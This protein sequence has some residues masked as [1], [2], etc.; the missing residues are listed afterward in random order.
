MASVKVV[1]YKWKTLK[2]GEHPVMIRVIKDRIDKYISLG[3][4]CSEDLW[5]E[6]TNRPKK[7][8]PLYR[9][10]LILI[11]KKLLEANKLI[12]NNENE[13]TEYTA[14]ELIGKIW[15]KKKYG[16]V[17]VFQFFDSIIDQLKI[18]GRIGYSKV[19]KNTKTSLF[20]FRG[21]KDFH[22]NDI[23]TAF[24]LKYEESF[25]S[26][27]VKPNSIFVFMRTLKTL[28]NYAKKNDIVKK[29][30]DPFKDYS[31]AKFRHI[32][33]RKRAL[34][35][36]DIKKIEE[37]KLE[38][39]SSIF[40]AKNYFLFSFY[41]RGLNFID[42]ANLKW[43]SLKGD[44]LN[45]TRKKTKEYFNI[46]LLGPAKDILK[47]Y[48][49][50]YYD[51]P[52]SYIFPILNEKH[53]TPASIDNR[54]HKVLKQTN[55]DLKTIA[56]RVGITD[57]LTTYVARH[58]YATILKKSGVPTAVISEALGHESEKITQVYLDSFENEILDKASELIL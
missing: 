46:A 33:T 5:D 8:H 47:Y 35:K 45:Y 28:I 38:P 58:S 31:F 12:L 50:L 36:L 20:T 1:L 14:S 6:K 21:G 17:T 18:S 55:A 42:L 57:K 48:K 15:T 10:K 3:I 25:L 51:G 7:K 24:I 52:D 32:K 34:D 49:E 30:Y 44:R 56:E 22:F 53:K 9:E 37:V 11:D 13:D 27:G 41:C 4:S 39:E 40:H 2:N 16:S 19:F 23:N 29:D 54:I 26:R 43:S